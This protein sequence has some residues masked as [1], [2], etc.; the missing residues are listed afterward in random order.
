LS[1]RAIAEAVNFLGIDK[2]GD[3]GVFF[4]DCGGYPIDDLGC[5]CFDGMD[6]FTLVARRVWGGTTSSFHLTQELA[7]ALRWTTSAEGR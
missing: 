6:G 2:G 3:I 1:W 7:E 4:S 5:R